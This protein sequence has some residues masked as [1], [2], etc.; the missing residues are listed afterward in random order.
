M[1]TE[2]LPLPTNGDWLV[3]PLT[4]EITIIE[5]TGLWD[6][7]MRTGTLS[8][9]SGFTVSPKEK[10]IMDETVYLRASVLTDN[11]PKVTV[12]R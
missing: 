12:A 3:V 1:L 5:N 2:D 11:T 4:S 8:T 10:Y 6:V 9:S 7:Y